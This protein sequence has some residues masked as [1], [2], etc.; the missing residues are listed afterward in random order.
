MAR[1]TYGPIVS[2]ARGAIGNTT[3]TRGRAG[4]VARSKSRPTNKQTPKQ[5]LQ[6]SRLSVANRG[7]YNLTSAQRAYWQALAANERWTSHRGA[8]Y[9]P[10][11]RLVWLRFRTT[12]LLFGYTAAAV[13][14]AP[15]HVGAFATLTWTL[16]V[17]QDLQTVTTTPATINASRI[18]LY[19]AKPLGPSAALTPAQFRFVGSQAFGSN[20]L[21][22]DSVLAAAG[23]VFASGQ[24][25]ALALRGAHSQRLPGPLFSGPVSTA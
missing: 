20:T 7:W 5:L 9:T 1:I 23:V 24:L 18:G 13:L 22:W 2:D 3:F 4:S 25:Y 14:V 8:V 16:T 19:L 10:T 11:G 12:S 21:D 15:Y 6:R 17:P